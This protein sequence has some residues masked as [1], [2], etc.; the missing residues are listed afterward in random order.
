MLALSAFFLL[1]LVLFLAFRV[2]RAWQPKSSFK[3]ED[4]LLLVFILLF[5]GLVVLWVVGVVITKNGGMLG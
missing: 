2:L 5:A 4:Y 3:I 1:G